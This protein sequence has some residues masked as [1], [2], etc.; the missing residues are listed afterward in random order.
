MDKVCA[1][2]LYLHLLHKE[3]GGELMGRTVI[4]GAGETTRNLI[5]YMEKIGRKFS[6]CF[7][8]CLDNNR[9]LLGTELKGVVIG[10]VED[11]YRY[12]DADIV[13]SSIYEQD[14]RRQL[15]ELGCHQFIMSYVDYKQL[16]F[17]DYQVQKY[18][19]LHPDIQKRRESEIRELTVYTVIFGKYDS[20]REVCCSDNRIR[21]ICFTDDET[22]RSDTWEIY[23]VDREFDDPILESRKYKMLPHL[24]IN[25]E[26]SLY[27]DAT[28]LFKMSPLDFMNEYLVR[29]NILFVPHESRD[30]IYKEMATC[31]L[32]DKDLPQRLVLQMDEYSKCNCPEHS[33]LFLGGVIGRRHYDNDVMKFDEEWWD[34]FKQYSRRDQISLGYL[35]WKNNVEISLANINVCNNRWF[36][37]R[38]MHQ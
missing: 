2:K 8:V 28:V 34:H 7:C 23:H 32:L 11:I 24:Y 20:L 18:E 29:G 17:A 1:R 15:A 36:D 9:S 31:I 30:C 5:K 37:I 4:I 10:A 27:V 6:E 14:I 22:L 3:R 33:G 38:I 25:T 35:I 13:I 26:Y 12:P 16:I 19:S 21:Y